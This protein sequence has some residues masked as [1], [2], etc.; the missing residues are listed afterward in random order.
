MNSVDYRKNIYQLFMDLI[1]RPMTAEE[2]EKLKECMM[3][4]VEY[5]KTQ[6]AIS[7]KSMEDNNIKLRKISNVL[8]KKGQDAEMLEKDIL[9]LKRDFK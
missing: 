5:Y 7:S 1:G 4:Y 9:F 8:Y 6:L 2:H 3:S